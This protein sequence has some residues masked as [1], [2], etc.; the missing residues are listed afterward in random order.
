V[1]LLVADLLHPL[2]RLAVEFLLTGDVPNLMQAIGQAGM[3]ILEDACIILQSECLG[4]GASGE[5]V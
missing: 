1:V 4:G 2:D 5:G 3:T